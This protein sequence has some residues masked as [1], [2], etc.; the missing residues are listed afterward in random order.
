[1]IAMTV[2]MRMLQRT[3]QNLIR[4][5]YSPSDSCNPVCTCT[6]LDG[7]KT[8]EKIQTNAIDIWI[9]INQSIAQSDPSPSL[10]PTF[11]PKPTWWDKSR[12]KYILLIENP[13]K[14]KY[15]I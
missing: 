10:N 9:E 2:E 14:V 3:L 15:V 13:I 5:I 4:K 1:M 6:G 11:K 12:K 7:D 8:K